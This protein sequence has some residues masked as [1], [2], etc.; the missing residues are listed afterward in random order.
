MKSLS[1]VAFGAVVLLLSNVA[2]AEDSTK[3]KKI[4]DNT[5]EFTAFGA[6]RTGGSF[7]TAEDQG[8]RD[9]ASSSGYGVLLHLIQVEGAYYEFNY[10]KQST[11]VEGV[12]PFDLSI[13]YFQLGGTLEFAEPE[14]PVK[15]YLA[16]TV[17]ATR[18][19]PERS[20]LEE[21]TAASFALGWGARIPLSQHFALRFEAR[22]YASLLNSDSDIFC[23]SSGDLNCA[24]QVKGD[25]FLQGQGFLG[26]TAG[27]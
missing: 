16:L 20:E 13:E 9:V 19:K 24:F 15:P 1:S 14:W 18:F 11:E 3:T 12:V 27:F 2:G 22:V 25:Y 5:F 21:E 17:G 6:Y 4:K 26:V 7:Q 23:A 8:S 10:S